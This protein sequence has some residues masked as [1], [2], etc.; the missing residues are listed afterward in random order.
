MSHD[1][2]GILFKEDL[3]FNPQYKD[4]IR[5]LI[6]LRRWSLGMDK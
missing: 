6:F 3:D 5:R 4:E 2:V 1:S